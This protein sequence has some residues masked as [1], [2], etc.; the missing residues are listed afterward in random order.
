ME[1]KQSFL[2]QNTEN[3]ADKKQKNDVGAPRKFKTAASLRR[4]VEK[5][6]RSISTRVPMAS[7]SG[8]AILNED[9]EAIVKTEYILPPTIPA[10]CL[11]LGITT[12]TWRNYCNPRLHPDLEEVTSD[13]M[14]RIEAYLVEESLTREKGVQGVIFN[15]TANYGYRQKQEIELGEKTREALPREPISLRDKLLAIAA[16]RSDLCDIPP[17]FEE[18]DGE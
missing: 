12:R 4:A 2:P 9:G 14:M 18:G 8:E 10:M 17:E 15:L 3:A 11:F 7:L 5:Y 16:A 13:A 6:F 1:K